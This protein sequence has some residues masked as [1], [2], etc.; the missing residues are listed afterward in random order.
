MRKRGREGG[1]CSWKKKKEYCTVK[2]GR[3]KSERQINYGENK[4]AENEEKV[5]GDV[6]VKEEGE[7]REG[8]SHH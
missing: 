8:E 6:K 2:E 7:G 5:T 3:R 4:E 1:R